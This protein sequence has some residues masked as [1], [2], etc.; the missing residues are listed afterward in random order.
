MHSETKVIAMINGKTKAIFIVF[1]VNSHR[2]FYVFFFAYM[3][4]YILFC[5]WLIFLC[6]FGLYYSFR[7][8]SISLKNEVIG[9]IVILKKIQVDCQNEQLYV[10]SLL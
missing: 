8:M 4:V 3:A 1:Q 7:L 2:M 5:C 6:I 10:L 9:C